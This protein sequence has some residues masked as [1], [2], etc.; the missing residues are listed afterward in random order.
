MGVAAA[1]AA[2]CCCHLLLLLLLYVYYV[3]GCSSLPSDWQLL[4]LF[5]TVVNCRLN[6]I[7]HIRRKSRKRHFKHQQPQHYWQRHRYLTVWGHPKCISPLTASS[8]GTRRER[9]VASGKWQECGK[10][11]VASGKNFLWHV[12][13][14]LNGTEKLEQ[15]SFIFSYLW[16]FLINFSAII[17][18]E[19]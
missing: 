12:T 7:L 16:K 8:C 15:F 9:G 17:S 11:Q 3:V 1:V 6:P 19:F 2:V 4:Q 14:T 18:W 5:A 13:H 10:W